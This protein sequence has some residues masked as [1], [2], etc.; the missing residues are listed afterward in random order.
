M[1]KENG[2]AIPRSRQL[3]LVTIG[4]GKNQRQQISK[5]QFNVAIG[6]EYL[7]NNRQRWVPI[8]ELARVF[9]W[10]DSPSNRNK[11]RRRISQLFHYLITLKRTII[12]YEFDGRRIGAV[13]IFDSTSEG[14]R[15]A[16]QPRLERMISRKMVTQHE[17]EIV[18][19]ILRAAK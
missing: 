18:N 11:V 14:D 9:Y 16:I 17:L 15:Q 13:K 8:G 2:I 12:V 4:E 19:S 3:E 6:A 5:V 10:R 1:T 7:L